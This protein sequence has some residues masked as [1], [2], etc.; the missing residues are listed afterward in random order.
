MPTP[1]F[2][3]GPLLGHLQQCE[4]QDAGFGEEIFKNRKQMGENEPF[5][6][7]FHVLQA[8]NVQN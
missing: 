2:V 6:F 4:N 1:T 5:N 7:R 8:K 3:H